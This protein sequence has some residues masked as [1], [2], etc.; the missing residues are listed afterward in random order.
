MQMPRI[1]G[2][3]ISGTPFKWLTIEEAVH[4]Y[5]T[6]KVAWDSGDDLARYRGGVQRSTGEQSI[7]LIKPIIAVSGDCR[8]VE[9]NEQRLTSH[10]NSLLFK[11]DHHMCAYCG[12]E[13]AD[14]MLER[15]HVHAR[16]KGGPD[17]WENSVTACGPCNR[18]KGNKSLE[19]AGM[20]L[21]YVPYRPCRWE[22]FI[23]KQRLILSD[24][25]E[26]LKAKLPKHSRFH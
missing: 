17:T 2:L 1:L 8:R 24:Q 18:K 7:I 6:D 23:L 20:K 15:D 19:E 14:R 10:E 21:L 25:M 5:A 11:R 3:D 13:F 26:Y 4:Y 22:K 9:K 16:S 12:E